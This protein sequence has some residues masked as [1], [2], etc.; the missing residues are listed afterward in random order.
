MDALKI[1]VAC[2]ESQAVTKEL[3][4]LGH[5]AYSCD[6]I[7][8]SGGH[9]EWHIM[10][11]VLPL[12]N[13]DCIFTTTDGIPHAVVGKWDM[14]IAFPPCT[15]LA[16]SGAAWFEKKRADGRQRWGIEFFCKFL[17]A[18]CDRISIE[19]P[20]GIISGDYVSQWFPDLAEK[21]DLPRK[22]TQTLHPWM[23][24]DNFSKSTCLWLKG[25]DP[26]APLVAEQPPLE[27]F[28][29]VDGKTGKKKKQPKWYADAWRLPPEE[30]AK[31]RSKT[32]PGIAKAMA[33]QWAGPCEGMSEEAVLEEWML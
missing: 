2:E 16:V 27:Y 20:I 33:E 8:Q 18:D 10:Q 17:T 14:L 12:L 9:P 24:G 22:P 28:E 26:L 15:H 31:V 3:R 19:N 4:R 30:R 11:D 7:D 32:F 29:W 13:G 1:L 6:I 23:F 21:Y 5:E 25:L